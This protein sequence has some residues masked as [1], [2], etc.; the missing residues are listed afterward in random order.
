MLT[1]IDL[2]LTL[3]EVGAFFIAG[4]VIQCNYDS[5]SCNLGL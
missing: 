1:L 5:A 3:A 2:G 4:I